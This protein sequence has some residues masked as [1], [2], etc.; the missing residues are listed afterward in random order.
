MNKKSWLLVL[1]IVVSA[2]IIVPFSIYF[3]IN[4]KNVYEISKITNEIKIAQDILKNDEIDMNK[5]NNYFSKNITSGNN[6]IIEKSIEDYLLDVLNDV[7]KLNSVKK[8]L[9]NTNVTDIKDLDILEK[10]K[11][12]VEKVNQELSNRDQNLYIKKY[13]SNK[14]IIDKYNDLIK[15]KLSIDETSKSVENISVSIDKVISIASFLNNNIE[16]YKIEEQKIVLL[17]R[18]TFELYE[19]L[20][21]DLNDE[22][23][24][25]IYDYKLVD[26]K[27]GPIIDAGGISLLVGTAYDVNNNVK[28]YDEVD[29]NVD[30][31]I[32]GSYD[33][34]TPGSYKI[35]ISASDIAG[36][37]TNKEIVIKVNAPE[38][39][40]GPYYIEIIRNYSTVIVY[41]L[42]DNGNF[43]NIVKVF[44]ASVGAG[45]NTP[46]GTFKTTKG[47]EWGGLY[48]GVYGQ[49]T[50][51]IVGSILFHSVPYY[52]VDKSTLW[53][54][55][56]NRLGQARSL[57]CIRLTVRDA[58]WIYDNCPSGTT[59][60]IYEGSLP[61]G[62]N[63]PSAPYI[64]PNSPNRGW[65][66]TDP[67][68]NN[69]WN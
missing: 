40:Q 58:K 48:G 8:Y 28:C 9:S 54:E 1:L 18:S 41:G 3:Y 68:P 7:S 4:S 16:S 47:L 20:V 19:N 53:W 44:P 51:R 24:I 45:S 26:D 22:Y 31:N 25:N 56:Y 67:D 33:V 60:R 29:G 35:Q 43:T 17:N 2:L 46:I 42:D 50:T 49:Y 52:S 59:V 32:S 62:V 63:K 39:P 11:E 55:E 10:H 27:T 5:V 61:A 34:N 37:I 64:D 69:P 12:E 15:S 36:N 21:S 30:C 38:Q 57:G 6:L 65:D 13:T 23:I 14:K 66:P